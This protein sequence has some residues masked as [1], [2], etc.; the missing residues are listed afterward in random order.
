MSK[1]Y[2]DFIG[3]CEIEAET[4]EEAKEKFWE[5]LVDPCTACTNATYEIDFVEFKDES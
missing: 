4:R 5:T 2:I 3:Y 1:F